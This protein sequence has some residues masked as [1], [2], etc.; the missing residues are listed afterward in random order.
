MEEEAAMKE[1]E[2]K[3]DAMAVAKETVVME[4]AA[5]KAAKEAEETAEEMEAAAWAP[6]V[7]A[8][9]CEVGNQE[10]H[11]ND[12]HPCKGATHHLR[13]LLFLLVLLLLLL[14]ILLM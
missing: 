13:Q 1:A 10:W 5:E 3:A 12:T 9:V 2:A 11:S 8:V 7:A 4:A 6:H 14:P